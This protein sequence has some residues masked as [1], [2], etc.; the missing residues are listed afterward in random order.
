MQPRARRYLRSMTS[1]LRT[2]ALVAAAVLLPFTAYSVWVIAGHGYTGFLSLAA[3][4]PWG[5]QMLLD[6]VLACSFG[7]GWM[8][9]DARKHRITTWPFIA[10]TIAA[11]SCGLL[12]YV[13][14][15]AVGSRAELTPRPGT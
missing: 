3:R 1:S 13:V 8:V 9:H 2:K 6:L 14:Y 5:M 10:M 15:R 12:G 4:E 7:V 11:G